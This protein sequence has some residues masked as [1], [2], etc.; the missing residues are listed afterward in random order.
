[1]R[2]AGRYL[3]EYRALRE[4]YDFRTLLTTPDL[5]TEITLQPVNR[6]NL[7]AAIL[8]SD[9]LVVPEMFGH[10]FRLDPGTGPVFS[11]PVTSR[12]DIQALSNGDV[13][14]L[15]YV[16]DSIRLIRG[17]LGPDVALIG[18]SGAPWTIAAYLVEGKPT[19]DFRRV[20][21][22][23]Y[24]DSSLFSFLL[25][26]LKEAIIQYV[27]GQIEAGA[28]VIQIFESHAGLLTRTAFE[29]YSLPYIREIVAS[30]KKEGIPV[31]LFA[32]GASGWLELVTTAGAD[33]MAVDWTVPLARARREVGEEV[34]LQG[35]LDPAVL[36]GDREV[37]EE[38]VK[39][40][41]RSYGT[42]HRHIFNLGHGIYPD[43]PVDSVQVMVDTVK[44]E[45]GKFHS[46]VEKG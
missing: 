21:G 16:F 2:Q 33:V 18:F 3:P 6:F 23:M 11:H 1:M 26:K 17:E 5:V 40:I 28:D 4:K 42:G 14:R 37:I 35:N 41:L 36:Y 30:I 44:Q 29:R 32:R 15:H 20:R 19:R 12:S 10:V 45:S 7:D 39:E 25:E 34:S 9:I 46:S 24:A 31:I 13:G 8:F 22:M 38:N 27:K 43:T